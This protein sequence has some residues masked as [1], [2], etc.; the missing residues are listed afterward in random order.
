M[1]LLRQQ[2]RRALAQ[3]CLFKTRFSFAQTISSRSERLREIYKR[4]NNAENRNTLAW[5][6]LQC[7]KDFHQPEMTEKYLEVQGEMQ[8][9]LD[10]VDLSKQVEW[11]VAHNLSLL[12]PKY[13]HQSCFIEQ[14]PLRL[15]DAVSICDILDQ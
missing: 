1:L 15:E 12:V 8:A 7:W 14:N 2:Y 5:S 4:A 10:A 13:T 9:T 11:P 3:V 6:R